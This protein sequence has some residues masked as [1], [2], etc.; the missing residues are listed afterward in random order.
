M[1]S[2]GSVLSSPVMSPHPPLFSF[3]CR[4]GKRSRLKQ[5]HRHACRDPPPTVGLTEELQAP[6]LQGAR[7]VPERHGGEDTLPCPH[8]C[9]TICLV[10]N[11]INH[12]EGGGKGI[13]EVGGE[14]VS[15]MDQ[16]HMLLGN[17]SLGGA[18]HRA[19]S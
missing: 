9:G 16:G 12:G 18:S 1:H 7:R 17:P 11:T 2:Q 3:L 10:G 19:G 6:L 15:F 13:W 4:N 14:G 5:G 8:H